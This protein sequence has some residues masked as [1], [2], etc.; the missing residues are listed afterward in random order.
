MD[1]NKKFKVFEHHLFKGL[2]DFNRGIEREA[3]R[4]LPNGKLARTPF[5]KFLGSSL[6]NS[7][8][9]TDFSESQLEFITP[10]FLK[11]EETL[12]FL[13]DTHLFFYSK[14]L[15][16]FLWPSS[17]PCILEGEV[18]IADYGISNLGKLKKI[19]RIGLKNRYGDRMQA[20][21]GLHYNFSFVKDYWE[22]LA[23]FENPN[24]SEQDFISRKYFALMRN[25]K[26][27]GWILLYFF[28]S[29]PFLHESFGGNLGH[30][31]K[32]DKEGTLYLP[33]ATSLR[34]SDLGY[35]N[36]AQKELEL[37]FNSL[38]S[39]IEKIDQ[40]LKTTDPHWKEI[41][42]KVNGDYRQM[43]DKILQIEN[44]YYGVIRPKRY[45]KLK[46]VRPN[47]ILKEE[48][49]QYLEV[50]VMDINPFSPIGITDEQTKFLD[51]LL[52][53]C[54][55]KESP[56]CSQ[57]EM[58]F[59]KLNWGEVAKKGRDPSLMLNTG[60]RQIS[61]KDWAL[62]I[63][64]ELKICATYLDIA[65]ET[66]EFSLVV[67]K[68]HECINDSSK[69][70]SGI[71][72]DTLKNE[73]KSFLEFHLGNGKL[74]KEQ[75]LSE[76]LSVQSLKYFEEMAKNSF[77]VQRRLESEPGNFDDYIQEYLSNS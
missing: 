39:Y 40:A 50:R 71:M 13:R 52:L 16:E 10:Y 31:L 20:I 51:T 43:N 36:K 47:K 45:N 30:L 72:I 54:S 74:Y 70:F 38:D 6:T 53:Y 34:M 62:E 76:R 77:D 41:G 24:E 29:T 46:N 32:F 15:S 60:K 57:N 12:A 65:Q 23:T 27:Y 33:Y 22:V 75:L 64:E 21:S 63:Y 67:K 58:K 49:V 11:S 42:V 2:K 1:L 8:I 7:L 26:R 73:K 19:Y 17:M 66:D 55:L 4:N 69:T 37:C 9:T 48:G 14:E 28:G 5:P 59:L 68:F 61:I 56:L 25:F 35:Q 3:L 44:E 18:P